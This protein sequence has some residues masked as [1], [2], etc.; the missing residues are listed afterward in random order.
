MDWPEDPLEVFQIGRLLWK[1]N[2]V[3]R[4]QPQRL[5]TFAGAHAP[6][7]EHFEKTEKVLKPPTW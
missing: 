7:L 5:V 6:V 2:W 3:A 4:F 1:L